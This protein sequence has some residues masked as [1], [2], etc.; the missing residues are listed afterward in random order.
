MPQ[1]G[2][3]PHVVAAI[4]P[5]SSCLQDSYATLVLYPSKRI[6]AGT[7]L[8]NR[9]NPDVEKR[10]IYAS[11]L[12]DISVVSAAELDPQVIAVHPSV[13]HSVPAGCLRK[14]IVLSS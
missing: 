1:D 4:A 3:T 11:P 5:S 8:S 13:T 10:V 2:V 14:L 7:T 9:T 6:K 12:Q